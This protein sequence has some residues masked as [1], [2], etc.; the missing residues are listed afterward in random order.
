MIEFDCLLEILNRKE[1]EEQAHQDDLARRFHHFPG[2]SR[3]EYLNANAGNSQASRPLPK[4]PA[5]Q[6][7]D[8]DK[9]KTLWDE[10]HANHSTEPYTPSNYDKDK[11][12]YL[13][14]AKK[15][16]PQVAEK[17]HQHADAPFKKVHDNL[18]EA[19]TDPGFIHRRRVSR[20][21]GATPTDDVLTPATERL[22]FYKPIADALINKFKQ[23]NHMKPLKVPKAAAVVLGS[24]KEPK[25]PKVPKSE[26]VSAKPDK[27]PKS[28]G[29]LK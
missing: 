26:F 2:E 9:L 10:Y 7:P 22:G 19:F 23:T 1:R 16:G 6:F 28:S 17:M 3:A 20:I 14:V 18:K 13:S 8:A 5:N 12:I 21:I 25:P 11:K 4:S 15:W 29:N 27:I 24:Q